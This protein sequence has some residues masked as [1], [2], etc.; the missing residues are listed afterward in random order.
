MAARC[1]RSRIAVSVKGIMEVHRNQGQRPVTLWTELSRA[2][3]EFRAAGVDAPRLTAEVL[4]AHVLGWDRARVIAHLHDPLAAA[5]RKRF[6]ALVG[7]RAAGEPLQYLTGQQEF[8]GLLFR[9]T[10]AVLI[11]RPETEILVERALALARPRGAPVR[12]ADVG[13]GSGCIAIAVA[14]ELPCATGCATDISAG[15]LAVARENALRLG[16][17]GRVAF[18]RGDLLACFPA[19][20]VFDLILSNPPYVAGTDLAGLPGLVRDHEPHTALLGGESGLEMYRRLILQAAARLANAGHLLLEVG[21]GQARAVASLIRQAGLVLEEIV[22]DLQ[23]I[24][25][26]LVARNGPDFT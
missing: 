21:D 24:P 9:V 3:D 15:A 22:E 20:P 1:D 10:P 18:V 4:L 13:T 23:G 2:G 14:R 6:R 5:A 11:P 19:R 17:R 25:R 7:R 12:F 26:C 16:V 8:Y